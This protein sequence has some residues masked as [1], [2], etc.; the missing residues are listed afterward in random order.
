MPLPKPRTRQRL[1][2][3]AKWAV[4]LLVVVAVVG[5]IV[6][7]VMPDDL[8]VSVTRAAWQILGWSDGASGD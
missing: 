7:S 2:R 6:L 5:V 1:A 3:W 4:G 8:R